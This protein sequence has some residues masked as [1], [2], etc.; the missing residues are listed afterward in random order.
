MKPLATWA[1][2][3]L[4]SCRPCRAKGLTTR[5]GGRRVIL[6]LSP[7]NNLILKCNEK[8]GHGPHA[9]RLF[10]A[11]LFLRSCGN[12]IVSRFQQALNKSQSATQSGTLITPS[13]QIRE[14]PPARRTVAPSREHWSELKSSS[15]PQ[16][17]TN[18]HYKKKKSFSMY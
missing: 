12:I 16:L 2:T 9:T 13:P 10:H 3:L 7:N 5:V 14:C 6:I 1:L 18:F 17:L 15:A 4:F 11:C 8:V